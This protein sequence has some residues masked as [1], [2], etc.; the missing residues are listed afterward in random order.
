M[1]GLGGTHRRFGR[2]LSAAAAAALMLGVATEARAAVYDYTGGLQSFTAPVTGTYDITA[3]GAQGGN[4]SRQLHGGPGAE[5]GGYVRLTAGETLTLLVGGQGEE[6]S[7][8]GGGGGSFVVVTASKMALLV[9][10]GGGGAGNSQV[11]KDGLKTNNGDAGGSG[12]GGLFG[13]GGGGGFGL[14]A[15]GAAAVFHGGSYGFSFLNGG[16]GGGGGIDGGSGGYGGGGGGGSDGGGGGGGGGYSGGDG[17]NA[18][19]GSGGGSYL[20]A[21]VKQLVAQSGVR[22]GNGEIDITFAPGPTPGAGLAGLAALAFAGLYAR[23]RRARAASS[24]INSEP[25]PLSGGGFALHR[26]VCAKPA[27]CRSPSPRERGEGWGEGLGGYFNC[28]AAGKN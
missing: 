11:G 4:Y 5:I 22:S 17:G 13:G 9:A 6:Y 23:A 14:N 7:G 28:V 26:R 16:A 12:G 1:R 10:G 18:A 25:P 15:N 3:F 2:G 24:R 20:D 19:G 21:S 8:G 27:R